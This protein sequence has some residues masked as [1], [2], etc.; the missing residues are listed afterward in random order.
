M[1]LTRSLST[2]PIP[3][4]AA[5]ARI[6][7]DALTW[8]VATVALFD[9]P[10]CAANT[11]ITMDGLPFAKIPIE[12]VLCPA[13]SS[14]PGATGACGY[15]DWVNSMNQFRKIATE[16]LLGAKQAQSTAVKPANDQTAPTM[17]AVEVVADEGPAVTP[18]SDSRTRAGRTPGMYGAFFDR[19]FCQT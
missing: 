12:A 16:S 3:Q 14:Q 8:G 5:S 11:S 15:Y 13:R 18:P 2:T 4:P 1:Q 17:A 19:L 6:S 9:K 10:I 7:R